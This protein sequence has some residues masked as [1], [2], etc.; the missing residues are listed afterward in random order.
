MRAIGNFLLQ[1]FVVA[2]V[3]AVGSAAVTAVDG[4][5]W[6][7]L[8]LGLATAVLAVL[9][10]AWV[11]GRTEKRPPDEV[12]RAGAVSALLRG[13]LIGVALFGAV[14]GN[15]AFLG[16]YRI[17]GLGSPEGAAALFGFMAAAAVSEELLYR[18]ILFRTLERYLGTW[19][20]L[21]LTAVVFGAMHLTNPNATPLGV[22][23][24]ALAGGGM[25]ASA[26]VATRRLW[27]PIGLHFGWNFAAG[28]IF[29]TEVSGN[30]TRQGLVDSV[31]S[32]P[33]WI[34]GGDFG[35]EASPYT[36]VFGLLL[37]VAFLWLAHRRGNLVPFRG[38]AKRETPADSLHS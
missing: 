22:A 10:Y 1:F 13:L 24:V 20:T 17:D 7:T 30:G 4:N 34:T 8:V 9:A 11:V 16:Y 23:A 3:A 27:L 37:T 35:P 28:G 2:F 12:G 36:V 26:Y 18:G 15:L 25:L 5:P 29:S 6:L 33:A 14:I 38:R 19:V 21:V 32:G 31:T